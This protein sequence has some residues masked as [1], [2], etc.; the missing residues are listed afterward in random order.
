MFPRTIEN[1]LKIGRYVPILRH[2]SGRIEPHGMRGGAGEGGK[3]NNSG[4]DGFRAF[5]EVRIVREA[6]RKVRFSCMETY[7]L[8]G[9]IGEKVDG[10]RGYV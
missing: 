6:L 7:L 9:L 4:V 1:R 3:I 2:Q 10:S 8:F 5:C